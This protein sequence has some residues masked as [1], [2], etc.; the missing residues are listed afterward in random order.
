MSQRIVFMGSPD[1]AVP[2]LQALINQ[3]ANVVA[4]YTQPPRPKGRGQHLQKTAVHMLAEY[5]GIPVYHPASLKSHQE[6]HQFQQLQPDVAVVAAYGLILPQAILNTP[7][8]GCLNIHASLL[9]RWRGASPIQHAIWYGDSQSGV[10]IMQM[11]PGLDTGPVILEGVTRLTSSTTAQSLH[12]ELANMGAEMIPELLHE[13]EAKSDLAA[14]PQ[15]DSLATYAPLLRKED[16]HIDWTQTAEQIDRQIRAL[17][18]WPGTWTEAN[19]RRFKITQASIAAVHSALPPGT[20]INHEGH[21]AC[22]QPT[23]LKILQLQPD[24]A[25][26][27]EARA[28]VNGHYLQTGQRFGSH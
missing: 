18:P 17:N 1:F 13:L 21:V 11:E 8:H 16:G 4:V 3:D 14:T 19:A 5:C 15:N 2:A 6:Q 22:A 25:K 20:L 27:M 23:T 12:D 9:P 7:R 28:A 24:G 26:A 10:S